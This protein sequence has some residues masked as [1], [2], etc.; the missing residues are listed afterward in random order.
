MSF[1]YAII[2]AV[3]DMQNAIARSQ[4]TNAETTSITSEV[5]KKE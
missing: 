4:I 2:D 3:E 1:M 5:L